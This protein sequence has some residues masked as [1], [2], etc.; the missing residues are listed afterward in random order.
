MKWPMFWRS[1][2]RTRDD[3]L[4]D[5]VRTHLEM[6]ARDRIERGEPADEAR[7]AARREFGNVPLVK[8]TTRDMWRWRTLDQL[9]QDVRHSVRLLTRSPG[10]TLAAVTCIACGIG[11]TTT[12]FGAVNGILLRPLPYAEADRLVVVHSR[13]LTR[14][15]RRGPVAWPDMAAWRDEARVFSEIGVWSAGRGAV[16]GP[17]GDPESIVAASISRGVLDALRQRPE[18]GRN[19]LESDQKF[20]NHRKALI[21]HG[22]WQRR[23]GGDRAILGRTIRIGSGPIPPQGY[24]VIG[25]MPEAVAFPEGADLWTPADI[26]IDQYAQNGSRHYQGALARL[27]PGVTLDEANAALATIA[28]RL[29][30]EYPKAQTGWDAEAQ[31]LRD[32]LVGDHRR[33]L[34]M[35]QGAALLVLLIACANVANLMLARGASRARD[36]AI[37]MAIGAGR[38]RIARHLLTESVV[39]ASAGGVAGVLLSLY[40]VR[41]LSIVFPDGVPPFLSLSVDRTVLAFTTVLSIVTGVV[42]GVAPAWRASRVAP[43][44]TL[45]DGRETTG[46]RSR[47]RLRQ[48]LVALEVALSLILLIGAALLVRSD[49]TVRRALGFNPRGV[50]SIGVPTPADRYE[51]APREVFYTDLASRIRALPGVE[52]VGWAAASAPLDRPGGERPSRIAIDGLADDAGSMR[53]A[54]IYDV[55][56]GYLRATGVPLVRGRDFSPTDRPG[57]RGAR[58]F[59]AIVNEEFVRANL[60]AGD[61]LG[62]RVRAEVPGASSL[63]TP[64]FTIIGVVKD[65][66]QERPPAPIGPAMYVYVPL[67][68][69]SQ[70]LTVRTAL[71]DPLTLVPHVQS[72]LRQMDPTLPPPQVRTFEGA[73]AR[74]LWRER[75]Y[76][77][78]LGVFATL[79]VLLAVFGVY[80][81]VSYVVSQRQHEFGVRLALGS[82][83][84]Q[85]LRLVLGQGLWLLLI[86]LA[87]GAALAAELTALLASVLH[88]VPATDPTTFIGASIALGVVMLIAALTPAVRASRIDPV[89][90]LRS[91]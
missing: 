71:A 84:G 13:N 80:G 60:G 63:G 36:V 18:M 57:G 81:V 69:N 77:R 51:G 43:A 3:D 4:D 31:T 58:A 56:L 90:A 75:L 11:V 32:A 27:A 83:P 28:Q 37:R 65:F 46:G 25:V 79:A 29:Q 14:D 85:V 64:T 50:L 52:S 41:M 47:R 66:R 5:E 62:R 2:R 44:G 20:G 70:T 1:R 49:L 10:F 67:G 40:G 68:S 21:S 59:V 86:G 74:G 34:L 38:A 89:V 78:V 54:A 23:Y 17:E 88:N 15:L 6:A 73:I 33:P 16:S 30:A 82:T 91:E 76:E 7:R 87:I 53:E 72:I 8:E 22:L 26:D 19:F 55:N 9:V 48:T 42:F 12:I 61:P 45:R 24:T 35:F 39:L